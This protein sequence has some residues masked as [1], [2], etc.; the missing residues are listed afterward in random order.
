MKKFLALLLALVLCLSVFVACNNNTGNGEQTTDEQTT[1]SKTPDTYDVEAASDYLKTMN[2]DLLTN[3]E[4][5]SAFEVPAQVKIGT[6]VYTV[7]W[8][9]NNESVTVVKKDDGTAYVVTPCD[10]AAEKVEYTLTATITAPD[11][12]TAS[13]EFKLEVPALPSIVPSDVAVEDIEAEK[14]YKFYLTQENTAQILYLAGGMKGYYMQTTDD[15]SAAIDVY[16]EIVEGGYKLYCYEESAKK[17]IS[18]V[19]SADGQHTNAVFA[20][21]GVVYVFN[22]E[23]KTFVATITEPDSTTNEYYLGTYAQNTTIGASKISYAPTS[24]VCH[25]ATLVDSSSISAAD[26]VAAEKNALSVSK[27]DIAMNSTLTLTVKGTTYADVNIAWASDN[28][29][30]VVDGETLTIT[31]QETAQT[32]KLTATVTCGDASETVEFTINVAKK[33]TL[34]TEIIDEPAA[35]TAYTFYIAQAN[36]SQ[37]LYL[38]GGV[39]GRYLTT[40][41]NLNDAVDV[42]AE[43]V[44]GGYKFYIL[45][46][47]TKMYIDVYLNADNKESV[48]YAAESTCVYSYNAETYAWEVSMGEETYYLGTYSTYNTASASKTSYIDASKTRVSQFPLELAVI[49]CT[50]EY[51]ADCDTTCNACGSVREVT[52]T[53]TYTDDCDKACD[54][55]NEET[56]EAPHK[57]ENACDAECECGE[58]RVPAEHTDST[59]DEDELCDVCGA[60][61]SIFKLTEVETPA[62][63]TA[64]KF[65]L[66]QATLGKNLYLTGKMSGYYFA[67][68]DKAAEAVDV[69]V[70]TVDGGFKVYLMDG[71]AKKYINVY[72]SGNYTNVEFSDTNAAVF[73]YSEEAKTFIV[74]VDG[75]DFYLGTY[76]DKN[77]ISASKTSYITGDNAAN[78]GVTQFIAGFATYTCKH[79]YAADCDVECDLC[80]A[81]RE[82]T[83]EHTYDDE[84]D[85]ECGACAYTR[86]AP[87]KYENACDAECECGATRTPAAC[88]D[89]NSD[90]KCDVCGADI[91]ISNTQSADFDSFTVEGTNDTSYAASRTNAAGWTLENGRCDETVSDGQ[92][93]FGE[94]PQIIINGKTTAV[95]KLTSC[96]L[97]GG[98]KSLSVKY[99]YAFSENNGV[100]IKIN[101]KNANGEVVATTDI[102]NTTLAKGEAA[103]F[104]WTLDTA[105]E[106]EFV[107]EIVNN[108]PS[109]ST[110]NKDRYSLWDLTWENN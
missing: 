70:E 45:D 15:P 28:A 30:A 41:T 54:V 48:R 63:D 107:I 18:I 42:Y 88:V 9:T 35:D 26:K 83:A 50:H 17:Y 37:A 21:E 95:G 46:G 3:P 32:V 60:D 97:S 56:R 90:S 64:Y 85:A 102:S 91:V 73:S 57:Y 67:T 87:H 29:C 79:T 106:G 69:Y 11:A 7:T 75:T 65:V 72:K 103:E 94:F 47:T 44:E 24:F 34:S 105:V 84:C 27:T 2:K 109:N 68:T 81:T 49:S 80:G 4:T 6:A 14:A 22:T 40:T 74:N 66:Y 96:T 58:T 43:A 13:L 77:T 62:A 19:K 31:L 99:G 10:R 104:T 39:N 55:C 16:V 12:T 89:E 5:V 100:S 61:L 36:L 51:T 8:T 98:I 33:P 20:D 1:E 93:V 86:E 78:V 101:I 110:S 23:Y 92:I 108:C 25:L 76:N 82:T 52:A 71:E 59:E 53:H 38:D